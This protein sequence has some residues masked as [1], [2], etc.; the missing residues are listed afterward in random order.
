[1]KKI[2]LSITLAVICFIS[3]AQ[4][5]FSFL[6]Y[7][8]GAQYDE[9]FNTL[10]RD[11]HMVIRLGD[12]IR[13][14]RNI[15]Y[16]GD[17]W[18]SCSFGFE[19]GCFNSILFH[20]YNIG[21]EE[22]SV[23]F[24][25]YKNSLSKEYP[26]AKVFANKDR[27]YFEEKEFRIMIS[28]DKS[29]ALSYSSLLKYEKKQVQPH[30]GLQNSIL[31]LLLGTTSEKQATS[32]MSEKGFKCDQMKP[33][34]YYVSKDSQNIFFGGVIWDYALL[35]FTEDKLCFVIFGKTSSNSTTIISDYNDVSDA[36][37]GKY[38][39]YIKAESSTKVYLNDGA[40]EVEVLAEATDDG[41]KISLSYIN[42]ALLEKQETNNQSEL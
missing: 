36:L 40:E 22:S 8:F 31:G 29:F 2:M 24:E 10:S 27:L 16:D 5:Q 7:T 12:D 6:G 14:E 38:K 26:N 42:S 20:K 19:N 17:E 30:Q 21:E 25:K 15:V 11:E 28:H 33:S 4:P 41:Y 3:S 39:Q 18:S 1:M 37:K 32:I 9:I 13:V 35:A 23:L 34:V